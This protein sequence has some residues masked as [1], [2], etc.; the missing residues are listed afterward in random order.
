MLSLIEIVNTVQ[1]HGQEIININEA[2]ILLCTML[3]CLRREE[4][5]GENIPQCNV[6]RT[7][8]NRQCHRIGLLRRPTVVTMD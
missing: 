2:F 1:Y 3:S 8:H 5:G 7:C 4:R 6:C